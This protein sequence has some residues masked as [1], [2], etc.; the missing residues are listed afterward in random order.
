MAD[1]QI[2][3]GDG[4]QFVK[5]YTRNSDGK[6]TVKV[7][8]TAGVRVTITLE[9]EGTDE[10][11]GRTAGRDNFSQDIPASPGRFTLV[12]RTEAGQQKELRQQIKVV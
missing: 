11:V 4:D 12:V 3:S 5:T 6:I 10:Y 9:A 8:R 2:T 1:A 7:K